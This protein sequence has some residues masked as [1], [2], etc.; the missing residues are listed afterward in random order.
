[1]WMCHY[2]MLVSTTPVLSQ[3]PVLW[4]REHFMCWRS[5]PLVCTPW[6]KWVADSAHD[7]DWGPTAAANCNAFR[8]YQLCTGKLHTCIFITRKSLLVDY[9]VLEFLWRTSELKFL[10]EHY[11]IGIN[12][13]VRTDIVLNCTGMHICSNPYPIVDGFASTSLSTLWGVVALW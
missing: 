11:K 8:H 1:M 5:H 2:G 10:A 12:V 4:R 13:N 7:D 3:Q 6:W 9:T